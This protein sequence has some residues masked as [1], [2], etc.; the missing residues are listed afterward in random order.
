MTVQQIYRRLPPLCT[1]R[2]AMGCSSCGRP[3]T[4]S[5]R[6][7]GQ[8]ALVHA[9][10]TPNTVGPPGRLRGDTVRDGARRRWLLDTPNAGVRPDSPSFV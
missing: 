4:P 6:P 2:A 1:V 9:S 7:L 3:K 10:S 5:G 8:V